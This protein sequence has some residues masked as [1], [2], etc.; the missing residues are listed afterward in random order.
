MVNSMTPIT[1]SEIKSAMFDI[2]ALKAP[3]VDGYPAIF[4]QNWDVVGSFIVRCLKELW[5][6]PVKINDLNDRLSWNSLSSALRISR[7]LIS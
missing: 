6:E 4:H 2:R 1:N 7:F 5:V 3:G